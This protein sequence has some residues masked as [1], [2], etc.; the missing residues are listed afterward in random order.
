MNDCR[1]I[2]RTLALFAV[3]A[4]LILACEN[5]GSTQPPQ[6]T[7]AKPALEA[8]A[9]PETH[10]LATPGERSQIVA[11]P[12]KVPLSEEQILGFSS[13]L[14]QHC[15]EIGTYW[16]KV[17]DDEKETNARRVL[18]AKALGTIKYRPAIPVL[19][20]HIR[21]LDRDRTAIWGVSESGIEFAS[22]YALGHQYG[23]AAIPGIINAYLDDTDRDLRLHFMSSIRPRDQAVARTYFLGLHA[24]HDKRITKEDFDYFP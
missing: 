7:K 24:Q 14:T 10:P 23:I 22:Q 4:L 8:P 19:I 2:A 20:K 6:T 17:L 1:L 12:V 16:I 21:L 9:A 13:M 3:L 11:P 5:T 15:D 18:A